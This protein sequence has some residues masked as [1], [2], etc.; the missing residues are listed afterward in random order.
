MSLCKGPACYNS[1][2]NVPY[3]LQQLLQTFLSCMYFMGR[4]DTMGNVP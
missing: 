1:C 4:M 3:G 2:N